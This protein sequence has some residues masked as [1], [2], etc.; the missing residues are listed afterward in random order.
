MWHTRPIKRMDTGIPLTARTMCVI[1]EGESSEP[2]PI[3]WGVPQGTVLGLLLFFVNVNDMPTQVSPGATVRLLVDDCLVRRE[4][5]SHQD[6]VILHTVQVYGTP[7]SKRTIKY[8][9]RRS[10]DELHV[11]ST[12]RSGATAAS[13]R[14]SCCIPLAGN[15]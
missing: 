12:P 14:P 13:A 2:T 9:G 5:K 11:W 3:Q 15:Y 1:C 6:Q 4:V 8:H 7:T 10:I